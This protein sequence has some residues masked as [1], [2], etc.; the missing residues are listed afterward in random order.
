MIQELTRKVE[1][2]DWDRVLFY[3]RRIRY[4]SHT[5]LFSLHDGVKAGDDLRTALVSRGSGDALFANLR[6]LRLECKKS[7]AWT[8]AI[9][10]CPSLTSISLEQRTFPAGECIKL[11]GQIF[12][13][14]KGI[15]DITFNSPVRPH[16]S[17]TDAIARYISV[18]PSLCNVACHF[19]ASPS[20]L[21]HLSQLPLLHTLSYGGVDKP[22]ATL[23]SS[24]ISNPETNRFPSLLTL[25][26]MS[27]SVESATEFIRY[28]DCPLEN[29]LLHFY[30]EGNDGFL[31]LMQQIKHKFGKSLITLKVSMSG[32]VHD[33]P[34]PWDENML[35]T[36]L[37]GMRSLVS[38]TLHAPSGVSFDDDALDRLAKAAPLL[39]VLH[40]SSAKTGPGYVPA[41]TLVDLVN[42][43]HH[44][45]ALVSLKIDLNALGPLSC[46]SHHPSRLVLLELGWSPI[47]SV[48]PVAELL[49]KVIPDAAIDWDKDKMPIGDDEMDGGDGEYT[50]GQ[51]WVQVAIWLETLQK[52]RKSERLKG[53]I[54][55]AE[56]ESR[57]AEVRAAKGCRITRSRFPRY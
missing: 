25:S 50:F 38:F 28:L 51:R 19:H 3:S 31:A 16:P 6:S 42:F 46:P 37:N 44:S 30:T 48:F 45:P 2:S 43:L 27:S 54:R 13:R 5:R 52:I 26:M 8:Y 34:G 4:L 21:E 10:F 11:I 24:L 14:C 9:L 18:T 7:W 29:F 53:R 41:A 12:R 23:A 15:T 39:E 49:S 17:V 1:S 40:F 20:L 55:I 22:L 47:D 33:Q 56:L 57:L 36:P 35:L 32:K